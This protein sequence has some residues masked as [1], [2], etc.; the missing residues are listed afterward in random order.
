[1]SLEKAEA[2]GIR[3]LLLKPLTMCDLLKNVQSALE[4]GSAARTVCDEKKA[5]S[6]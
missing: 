3:T 5:F 2:I 1:M 4:P 6:H